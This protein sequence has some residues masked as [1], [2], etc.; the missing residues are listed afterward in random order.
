MVVLP[1]PDVPGFNG[2]APVKARKRSGSPLSQPEAG[3]FNGAAPVK[4]RKLV[5]LL[6]ALFVATSFNGAAPV[7]ARKQWWVPDPL[8]W[9]CL[10]QWGRACEGAETVQ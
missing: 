6:L 8:L 3:C 1:P 7:K 10:L 4:A 5:A 2:A 9:S